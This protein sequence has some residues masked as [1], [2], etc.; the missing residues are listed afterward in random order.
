MTE[1]VRESYKKS[2]T[3]FERYSIWLYPQ[4]VADREAEASKRKDKQDRIIYGNNPNNDLAWFLHQLARG[5]LSDHLAGPAVGLPRIQDIADQ[6]EYLRKNH[7][8][9]EAVAEYVQ[10]SYE[11]LQVVR[12]Q[13]RGNGAQ[14]KQSRIEQSNALLE[15]VYAVPRSRSAI[16]VARFQHGFSGWPEMSNYVHASTDDARREAAAKL[17]GHWKMST[18]FLSTSCDVGFTL[19]RQANLYIVYHL[20]QDCPWLWMMNTAES[21]ILLPPGVEM[22][23]VRADA[24]ETVPHAGTG[25]KAETVPVLEVLVRPGQTI[26]PYALAGIPDLP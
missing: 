22:C 16:M 26:G 7:R 13:F 21:E 23:A 12:S 6:T 17:F 5:P 25:A 9:R 14:H 1:A 10:H 20:H 4:I 8:G 3:E 18:S 24:I 2:A 19:N 15:A 11:I